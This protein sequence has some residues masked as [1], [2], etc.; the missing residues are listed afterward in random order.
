IRGRHEREREGGGDDKVREDGKGDPPPKS[1][2]RWRRAE[3]PPPADY[4]RFAAAGCGLRTSRPRAYKWGPSHPRE[5]T[6]RSDRRATSC[7]TVRSPRIVR[8]LRLLFGYLRDERAAERR[9]RHL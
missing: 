6:T 7:S 4:T 3:Y 1:P 5:S 8:S 9:A 2:Y